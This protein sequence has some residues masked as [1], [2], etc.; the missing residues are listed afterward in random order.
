MY[1]IDNVVKCSKCGR[2]MLVFMVLRGK[3]FDINFNVVCPDCT[4]NFD[5]EN[6]EWVK[7]NPGEAE[8][9]RKELEGD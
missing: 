9:L 5:W 4:A 6:D 2:K 1:M 8:E 7:E 3:D